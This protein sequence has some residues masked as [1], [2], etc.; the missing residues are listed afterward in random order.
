MSVV[1]WAALI[2][3]ATG[4]I[5]SGYFSYRMGKTTADDAWDQETDKRVREL[6][7]GMVEIQVII[8][9]RRREQEK[10]IY[11]VKDKH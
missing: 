8:R 11:N 10:Q 9:E 4:A 2:G 1:Y 3:A 6:E 7:Q 5:V